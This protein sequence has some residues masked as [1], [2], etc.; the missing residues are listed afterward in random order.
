M[1]LVIRGVTGITGLAVMLQLE[2]ASFFGLTGLFPQLGDLLLLLPAAQSTTQTGP[3]TLEPTTSTSTAGVFLQVVNNTEYDV[4]VTFQ[5]DDLTLL[6]KVTKAQRNLKFDLTASEP[7]ANITVTTLNLNGSWFDPNTNQSMTFVN[8]TL[9]EFV[10]ENGVVHVFKEED[11]QEGVNVLSLAQIQRTAPL[12]TLIIFIA[13]E[14]ATGQ[15][16]KRLYELKPDTKGSTLTGSSAVALVE[17][18]TSNTPIP[19]TQKELKHKF[20]KLFPTRIKAVGEKDIDPNTGRV[21]QEFTYI[22]P[23]GELVAAEGDYRF[24]QTITFRVNA[25]TVS[26]TVSGP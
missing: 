19:G 25:T 5:A 7:N 3:I 23:P 15:I 11:V 16:E 1:G 9:D 18:A 21:V 22:P 26:F 8:G 14:T 17:S 12:N 2:C 20:V 6:A 24:G 13:S 4:E 10:D